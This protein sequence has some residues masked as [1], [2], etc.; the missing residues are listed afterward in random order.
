MPRSRNRQ[1]QRGKSK[2]GND[3]KARANLS[4]K[5][6]EYKHT[7]EY[8]SCPYN[9]PSSGLESLTGVVLFALKTAFWQYLVQGHRTQK[10]LMEQI[11]HE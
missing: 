3:Q 9:T 7:K 4:H 1:F 2:G 5:K 6:G 11:Q 8:S 10:C